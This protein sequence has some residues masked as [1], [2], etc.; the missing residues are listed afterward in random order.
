MP[1]TRK[2]KSQKKSTFAE[3]IRRGLHDHFIPHGGNGHLPHVLKHHVLFGYSLILVLVKVLAIVIPITL[4]S[5]SLYSSAITP[6][7]ILQLTNQT[8]RNVGIGDL[9]LNDKLSRA[10]QAKAQDMLAGQYFAHTSPSGTTPWIWIKKA[11]YAYRHAGENLAVHFSSAEEVQEG[12]MAS[13]S[14]RANIVSSKFSELGVGIVHGEFEGFPSIIVVEMFGHP[15]DT[16]A[17]ANDVQPSPEVK[18]ATSAPSSTPSPTPSIPISTPTTTPSV[19]GVETHESVKPS[20]SKSIVI[21]SPPTQTSSTKKNPPRPETVSK[22][23]A[24]QPVSSPSSPSIV[25]TTTTSI[26]TALPSSPQID[27]SS[28]SIV[29]KQN[30]VLLS[31][32]IESASSVSAHLGTTWIQLTPEAGTTMWRGSVAYDATAVTN[33]GEQ[34]YI[35]AAN[36]AGT[37]AHALAWIAPQRNA[38]ELYLF[39]E[40]NE[41]TAKILGFTVNNLDDRVTQFYV[42]TI[43]FLGT[44]LLLNILVKIRVQHPGII[45]HALVLIALATVLIFV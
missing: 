32:N 35:V 10:A 23:T 24:T 17:A 22:P 27:D 5:S 39:N 13:P 6:Q 38:K 14:H 26:I 7:N 28:L 21:T 9:K 8:R 44:A 42:Y 25:P 20:P 33:G 12:W 19:A 18:T 1:R 2:I 43:L 3:N 40:N 36:H 37:T 41:K 31:V 30:A 16:K 11:G 34:L 29:P 15:A 4:P 45:G